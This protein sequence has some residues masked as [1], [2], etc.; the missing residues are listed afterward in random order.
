MEGT[1]FAD[2]FAQPG[3]PERKAAQYVEMYGN[4]GLWANG[5]SI[6]TSHRLEPWDMASERPITEPWEL[7]DLKQDPGQT[8]DLAAKE[9]AR[10]AGMSRLF[11][12]QAER[13]HVNPIGNL[14]DGL[15]DSA[16]AARSDFARRGGIW[17]YPGPVGNIQQT[18][19]PPLS[20]NAFTMEAT[21]DLPAAAVSG[22]VFA[23]GGELGGI[24]LYLRRGTLV[25]ALNT[26][27]GRSIEIAADKPLGRGKSRIELVFDRPRG[28][29]AAAV[30]LKSGGVEIGR[31]SVPA[32]IMADF[33]IFELIGIGIDGGTPVLRDGQAEVP[34]PGGISEVVFD[35]SKPK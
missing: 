18:V 27:S 32:E 13:F 5:W 22:P 31:G 3:A 29:G 19:G 34:F 8:R 12:E 25:F 17:R 26:M 35:F 23:G 16:R 6:V 15:K 9:P 7:Y 14:V 28:P 20:S 4:K 1:S 21:L 24:A 2:S 33:R 10:L 11:E 30:S